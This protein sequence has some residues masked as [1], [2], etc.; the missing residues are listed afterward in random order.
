M[1]V[2]HGGVVVTIPLFFV[3]VTSI[4]L[5]RWGPMRWPR[6]LYNWRWPLVALWFLGHPGILVRFWDYWRTLI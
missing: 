6:T 4:A 1:P 5:R 3:V 2:L